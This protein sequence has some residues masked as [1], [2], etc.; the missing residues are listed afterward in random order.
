M[1]AMYSEYCAADHPRADLSLP[2]AFDLHA[3][4]VGQMCDRCRSLARTGRSEHEIAA[5]LLWSRD[6]VRRALSEVHR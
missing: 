6:L 4:T 5:A 3:S 1:N 2:Q